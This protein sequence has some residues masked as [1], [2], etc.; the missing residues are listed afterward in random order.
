MGRDLGAGRGRGRPI[1]TGP[2]G[3]WRCACGPGVQRLGQC[4]PAG[5][6]LPGQVSACR[7]EGNDGRSSGG[8]GAASRQA[9]PRCPGARDARGLLLSGGSVGWEPAVPWT[10]A[11]CAMGC[12][13]TYEPFW[14]GGSYARL[15]T[16]VP[17]GC[18]SWCPWPSQ[19]GGCTQ[20]GGQEFFF[21]LSPR[22]WLSLGATR[23]SPRFPGD[24]R[25]CGAG[26]ALA[27]LRGA[28]ERRA[29]RPHRRPTRGGRGRVP[30]RWGLQCRGG[31]PPAQSP[32]VLVA[33]QQAWWLGT[34]VPGAGC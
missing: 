21:C 5:P 27:R 3:K 14:C 6:R 28:Q 34:T 8:P 26:L 29:G 32:P 15:A 24:R 1:S 25:D 17:R 30:G 13:S 23:G 19:A 18:P 11:P 22:G 2:R 12:P 9:P 31:T 20:N 33:G 10:R 16:A 4:R 7:G